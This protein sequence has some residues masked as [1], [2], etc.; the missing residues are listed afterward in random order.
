MVPTL[1]SISENL[2]IVDVELQT[3]KVDQEVTTSAGWI[4]KTATTKTGSV[5]AINDPN[6]RRINNRRAK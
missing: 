2:S 6:R 5:P 1:N 3:Q 4:E